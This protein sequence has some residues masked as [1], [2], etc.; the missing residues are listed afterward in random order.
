MKDELREDAFKRY[1]QRVG[2]GGFYIVETL[3]R[4]LDRAIT[5]ERAEGFKVAVVLWHN[6]DATPLG[7]FDNQGDAERHR[8]AVIEGVMQAAKRAEQDDERRAA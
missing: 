1:T 3:R 8:N 7:V 4:Q 5:F 2:A 6:E